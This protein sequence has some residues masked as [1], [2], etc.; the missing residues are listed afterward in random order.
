[1]IPLHK[2]KV[3]I[4]VQASQAPEEEH[5]CF[6]IPLAPSNTM[7]CPAPPAPLKPLLPALVRQGLETMARPVSGEA[8]ERGAGF[9]SREVASEF[10]GG[11]SFEQ[12][13]EWL[14]APS[15]LT[16]DAL[17]AAQSD[18]ADPQVLIQKHRVARFTIDTS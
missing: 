6:S 2:S 13:G 11:L 10:L 12:A 1:M 18:A 9:V 4:L 16:A 5:K 3:E 7:R 8:H 17:R 14:G 15:W